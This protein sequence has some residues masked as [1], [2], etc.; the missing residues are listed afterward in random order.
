MVHFDDQ[1]E[2]ALPSSD[3][4]PL[5]SWH[6]SHFDLRTWSNKPWKL[7]MALT[8]SRCTVA[9]PSCIRECQSE[10]PEFRLNSL[11]SFV[12][13]APSLLADG[14]VVS[15]SPRQVAEDCSDPLSTPA[16]S[17]SRPSGVSQV[18]ANVRT[19]HDLP[20]TRQ[21]VCSNPSSCKLDDGADPEGRPPLEADLALTP[22]DIPEVPLPPAVIPPFAQDMLNDLPEGFLT[23][24]MDFDRGFV[25]RTWYIHHRRLTRSRVSRHLHIRGP[26]LSWRPQIVALWMDRLVPLEELSIDLIQP[27]PARNRYEQIIAFDL[28]VSQGLYEG[29]GAG[30]ISVYPAPGDQSIPRFAMAVSFPA[31]VSGHDIVSALNFQE[32]CLQFRCDMFFRWTQIPWLRTPVHDM[33]HGDG[34][35]VNLAWI[36]ASQGASSGGPSDEPRHDCDQDGSHE[37]PDRLPGQQ[38][39]S[40]SSRQS[41]SYSPSVAPDGRN[42]GSRQRVY[43]YR[44]N[45]PVVIAFVRWG[46]FQ[47]LYDDVVNAL[48]VDP[49]LV[50]TPH[51]VQVKPLG[52][53][54]NEASLIVQMVHDVPFASDEQ[55]ILVD[56]I[57]HNHGADGLSLAQQHTDRRVVAVQH[58]LTRSHLLQYAHVDNYCEFVQNRCLVRVNDVLWPL[59]DLGLR[60]LTHGTYVQIV[61]PPHAGT[62]APT[63]RTVEL[64]EDASMV[65]TDDR[66]ASFYPSWF[67]DS[68]ST[69][70]DLPSQSE[71]PAPETF[72]FKR[73]RHHP[74][75]FASKFVDDGYWA[76]VPYEH[77]GDEDIGSPPS[78]T[79]AVGVLPPIAPVG[80]GLPP[81][82]EMADFNLQF[83]VTF[84]DHAVVDFE[85]Q[86]P[87]LHVQ[88]WYVHHHHR[89]QCLQPM[90]VQL[91][92]NPATWPE[93][94]CAPWRHLIQPGVPLAFREV[95]PN[96]PRLYREGH[97]AHIILEQ[98]L[99]IPQY[100]ALVSI[101]AQGVH[102]DASVHLAVSVPRQV[103]AE[104]ILRE[105]QLVDRC[106]VYRCTVWSGVMQ[107]EPSLEEH[108]FSGIGIHVNIHGPRFRHLLLDFGSQPF[109]HLGSHLSASS[110]S[111]AVEVR[112]LPEVL[113][114]GFQES[115]RCLQDMDTHTP[116]DDGLFVPDLRVAWQTF[117][118]SQS[119]G[120]YQLQV[121]AWFCDHIRLPRSGESR[122][123]LLPLDPAL[124]QTALIQAWSDWVLP[125]L[126]VNFYVVKPPPLD[127][128]PVVAHV[129]LA[130]NQVE[131]HASVLISSLVPDDNPW[132]PVH[133]VV[134]LPVVIDHFM[135]LH[136]GGL[137]NMCPP[138]SFHFKCQSWIGARELSNGQ[139]YLAS[140][141]DG[142]LIAASHQPRPLTLPF[143]PPASRIHRLFGQ[144]STL[145]TFL[146]HQVVQAM[147]RSEVAAMDF[148]SSASPFVPVPDLSAGSQECV[149]QVPSVA[150]AAVAD[151]VS[152][153]QD[154][155]SLD[156]LDDMEFAACLMRHQSLW[157]P[158]SDLPP[159]H[160]VE[161]VAPSKSV[162]PSTPVVLSLEACLEPTREFDTARQHTPEC[163][164]WSV[165]WPQV[166]LQTEVSFASLPEYVPLS[167]HSLHALEMPVLYSEPAF[168]NMTV[169]YVDGS[170][171]ASSAAWSVI[172]V[173]YTDV[174]V[175][176]FA[177][178]LSGLVET[179]P[180]QPYWLGALHAD[181]IAAELTATL[182]ALVASLC[183]EAS[184]SVV[185]R[186]DLRLSAMLANGY[187][188][189]SSSFMC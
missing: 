144:M 29:R 158:P 64:V 145:L 95:R 123:V 129:I 157:L 136:E 11:D 96:P 148:Q 75:V 31:Q 39:A 60:D 46:P 182:A 37:D 179:C 124:W 167:P 82:E 186:P 163:L 91:E 104:S 55:L 42:E 189:S 159:A 183:V 71:E 150:V 139:L 48:L 8:P 58:P 140:S 1:I 20:C 180:L 184:T 102:H 44:L 113:P 99:H 87:V 79:T 53:Q 74:V 57:I 9:N 181:N 78:F 176:L 93:A 67:P 98:G 13:P 107:F 120:P 110:S 3:Q 49:V 103:S 32:V 178:C 45:Q 172:Q 70:A 141:G 97:S 69:A 85:A 24:A 166:L 153:P 169:Y 27:Q 128:L 115:Q 137:V 61:V 170:S 155:S 84:R 43:L 21:S 127:S 168:A 119:Q 34:F 2:V 143:D 125:G 185:I 171:N 54:H 59:Q 22:I 63:V 111:T 88:T 188:F 51:H 72:D 41:V 83:G 121:V 81:L 5:Q 164:T 133:R 152:T 105:I 187:P 10:V 118:A 4:A 80:P 100:V 134:K 130:Q 47:A 106:R 154:F 122:V 68:T 38:E 26:P 12:R 66:F 109:W 160:H 28:V 135:L 62:A 101:L 89:P 90:M 18:G 52:E 108:I 77:V 156:G 36:S 86:G 147:S 162:C 7:Q 16:V 173:V 165:D 131:R 146:T 151:D 92:A 17:I 33:N 65:F 149:T 114:D 174:G 40:E 138:L 132:E 23:G 25:I 117:L 175:P 73:N 15:V 126:A 50:V 116:H 30:L 76:P 14:C 6:M 35:A 56:L 94:L 161:H 19:L 177:G 142:F 112:R